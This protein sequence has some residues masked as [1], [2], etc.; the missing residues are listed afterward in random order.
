MVNVRQQF[1]GQAL[2]GTQ[3]DGAL[4]A[5]GLA[6]LFQGWGS[7]LFR[8]EKGKNGGGISTGGGMTV[9]QVEQS[10]QRGDGLPRQK[11]VRRAREEPARASAPGNRPGAGL[12]SLGFQRGD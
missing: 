1:S 5:Q 12:S 8:L 2:V 4:P 9:Q 7:R 11:R 10:P 6:Q 3:A